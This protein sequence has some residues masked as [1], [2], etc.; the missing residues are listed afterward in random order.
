MKLHWTAYLKLIIKKRKTIWGDSL[1][2]IKFGKQWK[3]K[4]KQQSACSEAA[5][6]SHEPAATKAFHLEEF[7]HNYPDSLQTSP[8]CNSLT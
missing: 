1:I 3:V 2:A 5:A 8:D 7:C 4:E 6:V